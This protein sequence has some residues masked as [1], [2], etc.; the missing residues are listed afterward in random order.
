MKAN[1]EFL[2][3]PHRAI[4]I[5]SRHIILTLIL[6]TGL[7]FLKGAQI[8]FLPLY[9]LLAFSYLTSFLF[10]LGFRSGLPKGPLIS[11][12]HLID[13]LTA[14]AIVHFSGGV[15]S[16]FSLL[17]FLVIISASIELHLRGGFLFATLSSLAYSLL[18]YS[19]YKGLLPG[20]AFAS[21]LTLEE[22]FL[23]GD[24]HVSCFYFVALMSGS[25]ARKYKSREEELEEMKL[26]T[27]DILENMELGV[28]T[29][30]VRGKVVYFNRKA[31]EILQCSAGEVQGHSI[32]ETLPSSV[33]S[34]TDLILQ[35]LHSDSLLPSSDSIQEFQKE[36][37]VVSGGRKK[38]L[39]VTSTLLLNRKGFKKGFLALFSDLTQMK[40][41]EWR[42][43]HSERMAAIG[44]LSAAI[45]HEIRNPLAS[46]LG[47]AE[48]LQSEIKGDQESKKLMS[49]IL[50]ESDRLNHIIEDFLQF[51]R[52]KPPHFTET[53]LH[54]LLDEVLELVRS[55]PEY[56]LGIRIEQKISRDGL[57]LLLDKDQMKQVFLNICLNG[58]KAMEGKGRLTISTRK[59]GE[60]VGVI[61]EDTGR[62]IPPENLSKIFEPFFTTTEKGH[63]LGLAIAHRILEGHHGEIQVSSEMGKGS[64]FTVWIPV[65]GNPKSQIPHP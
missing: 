6:G 26:T 8:S 61:F 34:L 59:E 62:G 5:L 46:I 25:I 2:K 53:S 28:I 16:P 33:H 7:F 48:Y 40:E 24:L 43:R 23:R 18:L 37:E 14:S 42:L 19:H 9:L 60:R 47:S 20:F 49:L 39:G 12:Q 65:E 22:V 55:H 64:Q 51:A 15:L 56:S 57:T 32:Q 63:G 50:R 35:G 44:E 30:D 27:E 54:D 58:I 1:G 4:E 31:G 52:S 11:L 21:E 38:P 41:T 45:A 3:G 36:I 17:Y 10:F 29:V 13:V